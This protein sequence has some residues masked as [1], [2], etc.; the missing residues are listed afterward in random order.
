[1]IGHLVAEER[2]VQ[3]LQAV[4]QHRFKDTMRQLHGTD[5]MADPERIMKIITGHMDN[6]RRVYTVVRA[7]R[8]GFRDP[9]GDDR[10]LNGRC[11]VSNA[12]SR[13]SCLTKLSCL[14]NS[15]IGRVGRKV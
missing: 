7:K 8:L 10:L 14:Q 12:F 4:A 15:A 9:A 2:K 6:Q 5:A 13:E 11:V 3:K 1:M